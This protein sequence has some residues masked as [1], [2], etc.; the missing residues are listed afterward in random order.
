MKIE[1][2]DEEA[3][4]NNSLKS[5]GSYHYQDAFLYELDEHPDDAVQFRMFLKH[6]RVRRRAGFYS[7]DLES[8]IQVKDGVISLGAL[9]LRLIKN[10]ETK[11]KCL[12]CGQHL[13]E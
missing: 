6:P 10:H 13:E 5:T 8:S 4:W 7:V 1:I 3:K 9:C 11:D 12:E 2:R